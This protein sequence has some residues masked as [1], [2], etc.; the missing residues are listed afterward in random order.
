MKSRKFNESPNILKKLTVVEA[1]F[2]VLELEEIAVLE[3]EYLS[4]VAVTLLDL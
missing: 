2:A 4:A 3:E 1:V